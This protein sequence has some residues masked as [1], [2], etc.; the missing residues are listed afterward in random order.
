MVN[1]HSLSSLPLAW[2]LSRRHGAFLVYEPHELETAVL[3]TGKIL[4]CIL[5]QLEKILISRVDLMFTVSP[6][7]TKEYARH[8]Q[9]RRIGTVLNVPENIGSPNDPLY[10]SRRRRKTFLYLGI[11]SAERQIPLLLKTFAESP[12][13]SLFLIGDGELAPLARTYAHRH[14]NI[15]YF[16]AAPLRQLRQKL[17]GMDFGLSLLQ[18]GNINHQNALPNKLFQ[19]ITHGLPVVVLKGTVQERL[20]EKIGMSVAIRRP[21]DFPALLRNSRKISYPSKATINKASRIYTWKR[22][23]EKLIS[24]YCELFSSKT[25]P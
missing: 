24:Y 1:A 20:L 21:E 7:I 13:H 23:K 17:K 9:P 11:L 4:K 6:S 25:T 18:P 22:E 5:F 16:P 19:Y 15:S 12:G 14:A 3:R 2:A 10:T 8:T